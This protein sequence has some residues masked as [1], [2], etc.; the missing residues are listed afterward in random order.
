[1]SNSQTQ[2]QKANYPLVTI[3]TVVYNAKELLEET[4]LS[5]LNQSYQN[6]EYIIIDGV[7]IDGTLDVIKN[8]KIILVSI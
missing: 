4:I 2:N 8:I 1:M 5:V 3:V 7:S 6:I